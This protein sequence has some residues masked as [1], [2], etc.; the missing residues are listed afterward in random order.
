[1]GMFPG[2][3][4]NSNVRGQLCVGRSSCDRLLV[5]SQRGPCC[6]VHDTGKRTNAQPSLLDIAGWSRANRTAVLRMPQVMGYPLEPLRPQLERL[7]YGAF[8][9]EQPSEWAKL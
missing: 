5:G 9:D 2:R 6:G 3:V 4:W 8:A 1:M 7:V